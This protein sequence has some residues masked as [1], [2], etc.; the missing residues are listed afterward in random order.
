MNRKR[1]TSRLAFTA[2]A[3]LLWLAGT[4]CQ[5]SAQQ[6]ISCPTSGSSGDLLFRG[7]YVQSY[8]G[9]NL[10]T[11]TLTY[12][13]HVAGTYTISLTARSG[14][15]SG[16]VIGT[17]HTAV[18]DLLPSVN[19]P[20]IFNFAGAP[21]AP[22]TLVTFSQT[23][24][25]G[26]PG[27]SAFFNVGPCDFNPA[28]ASCPGVIETEDQTPPLSTFRR[29]SVGVT[30]T[31]LGNLDICL[32]DNSNGNM[33]RFN[34]L[35]GNYV[36]TQ[37]STGL[38]LTGRGLINTSGCVIS[39]SD[40]PPSIGDSPS[41]SLFASVD[42]C[43]S[44][45]RAS[46]FVTQ[47]LGVRAFSIL[48]TNTLDNSCLCGVPPGGQPDLIP[49]PTFA[50]F[51]NRDNQG[52]LIITVKNQGTAFAETF[53]VEVQFEVGPGLPRVSRFVSSIEGL[54]PGES[55]DL[56]PIEIPAG[57]FGSQCSFRIIVDSGHAVPESNEVN[58]ITFG[59]CV[60]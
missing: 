58:N 59:S 8:P 41:F 11:V 5:A 22:G 31:Q 14:S 50:G 47:R 42:I 3:C 53:I 33:L 27:G 45:G 17:P 18:V 24:V 37:C 23:Q 13:T 60:G 9:T 54:L 19:T 7:F 43:L 30:I 10:G 21:V 35:T 51:C 28:C 29:G 57:C 46:V 49:V 32:Q 44:S 16:A 1:L 40:S 38:T 52:R 56:S 6:L 48:D 39:L 55:R 2:A 20:V 12:T 4:Q 26:P 34:T 15:Y 36:F 25:S